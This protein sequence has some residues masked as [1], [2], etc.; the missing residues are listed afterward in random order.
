MR[1]SRTLLA[2][3]LVATLTAVL[4]ACSDNRPPVHIGLITKQE[5]NPYWVTMREV[6]EDTARRAGATLTVATGSSDVDVDAQRQALQ[7]MVEK[8][9]DGILIA[10]TDS[11]A[12]AP[13][14]AAARQAGITV[15]ALDTP[16]DPVETTDAYFGTDNHRAG[17]LVGTYAAAKVAELGETPQVAMLDLAPG[18]ASG[19]ERAAGFLAGFGTTAP[20]ARADTQGDQQLAQQAM[21]ELLAAHPGINVVY[22]VNEPAALGA[23]TALK[24]AGRDL[25]RVVVVSIDGGCRAMKDSVRPGDIDATAMQ[26]PQN[27]ARE[28]V[29]AVVAKV[30]EGE[31]PSAH[32]ATGT[33]LVSGSP[34]S[35][36]QTRNVEYGIRTC[37]GS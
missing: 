31:A 20:T 29:K 27:M 30:R 21:T 14:I 17:E 6:A 33:E 37:W 23:V 15:I 10:P 16:M 22:A 4:G 7:E 9:V 28:G 25:G 8:K 5:T 32:L 3:I 18:I 35:G 12:L 2:V 19:E 13:E 11:T 24:D 26:F 36:V 34:V 1:T